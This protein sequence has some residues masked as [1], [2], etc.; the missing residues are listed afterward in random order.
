M[1][2]LGYDNY[3]NQFKVTR[4]AVLAHHVYEAKGLSN[5]N[6]IHRGERSYLSNYAERVSALTEVSLKC[7]AGEEIPPLCG[8]NGHF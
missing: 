5:D 4:S 3:S 8:Q 7:D 6:Q 2:N 1:Y